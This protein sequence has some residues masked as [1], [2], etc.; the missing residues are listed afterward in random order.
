[1]SGGV[2]TDGSTA[3]DNQG[4]LN[5][6]ETTFH[7]DVRWEWHPETILLVGA[8]FVDVD[9]LANERI[10]GTV[11][12]PTSPIPLFS[13]VRNNRGAYGYLGVDQTFRPD[14]TASLRAGGRYNDYYNDPT[15]QSDPS[16]YVMATARY[17]YQMESY[18]EAGVSYD[19]ATTDLFS[20]AP[21]AAGGI[22]SITTDAQDAALWVTLNHR[23]TPKIYGNVI[24]QVQ[25]STYNGGTLNND[26]DMYY[27]V[28]LTLEYR[29]TPNFSAQV[30][31]NYDRLDAGGSV[32]QVVQNQTGNPRSFDRNRVYLGVTA[33]Y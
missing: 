17:A 10:D 22:A 20:V 19:R 7:L 27:L 28:G 30:G 2:P 9:Y 6:V 15:T 26:S 11:N 3:P 4:L 21:N 32:T 8:Q 18:V 31:Y 14:L 5:R 1:V 24:A 13:R 12:G 23:I 25:N 29:F 16:P 33:S